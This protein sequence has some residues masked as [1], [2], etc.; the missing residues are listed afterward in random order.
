M[1][2]SRTQPNSK[3]AHERPPFIIRPHRNLL[4]PLT[5]VGEWNPPSTLLLNRG[6]QLKILL[7]RLLG[8]GF[9]M[10][11]RLVASLRHGIARNK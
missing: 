8:M 7:L 1:I 9:Q 3:E 11:R 4:L 10:L 6:T 2:Y 5:L